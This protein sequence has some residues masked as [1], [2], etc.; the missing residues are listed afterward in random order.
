[1]EPP[2]P[3]SHF[4][5]VNGIQLHYVMAGD[6]PTVM[7]LHGF[8]ETHRSWDLQLPTLVRAGFRV[9]APDLRGY[10]SS[11]RPR[12][13]YDIQT[14]AADVEAL[15]R[16]TSPTPLALVGHDWGGA[17]AWHLA[18]HHPSLLRRLVI[19]NCPHPV[20]M[21][22]SLSSD[23]RQLARS[24]YMLFFQLPVLPEWWLTKHEGANLVRLFRA[25][26]QSPHEPPAEILDASRRALLEPGAAR[27]AIAYYRHAARGW[28]HPLRLRTLRHAYPPI[29]VPVSILWGQQD[30]ALGESLLDGSGR[31]APDLEIVRIPHAG[32]F[33][34]QEEPD[35][36][37]QRLLAILHGQPSTDSRSHPS[38]SE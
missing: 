31:F 29:Q 34:H 22:E 20:R 30:S 8:P 6:G 24:W 35:T 36:V 21:A 13:G 25:S 18:T 27:A 10:G 33:V 1:M 32:H 7:L 16:T 14:L 26:F 11:D 23:V 2:R 38:P 15:I 28:F 37:N 17:V 4:A 19:L 5:Q 3:T 9:I 12:A